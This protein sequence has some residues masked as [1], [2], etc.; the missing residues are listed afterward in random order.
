MMG[1]TVETAHDISIGIGSDHL[2]INL[3]DILTKKPADR[4]RWP[5]ENAVF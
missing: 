3:E 4:T 2:V 5:K 1:F